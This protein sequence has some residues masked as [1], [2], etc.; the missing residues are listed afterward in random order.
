[1][2]A[3]EKFLKLIAS[4]I[5]VSDSVLIMFFLDMKDME[6]AVRYNVTEGKNVRSMP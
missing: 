2:K 5:H 4:K 3:Q 6:T 1:M